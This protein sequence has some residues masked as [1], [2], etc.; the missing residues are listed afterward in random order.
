MKKVIIAI[1]ICIVSLQGVHAVHKS[2]GVAEENFNETYNEVELQNKN[3]TVI[4]HYFEKDKEWAD[5]VLNFTSQAVILMEEITGVPYPPEHQGEYYVEVFG[6]DKEAIGDFGVEIDECGIWIT[7]TI[8]FSEEHN[9]AILAHEISHIWAGYKTTV[10]ERWLAEGFANL[11]AHLV[12]LRMNRTYEA[13]WIKA[14]EFLVYCD[15]KSA[16]D[17]PLD[18]FVYPGDTP[19]NIRFGYAKSM[20]FTYMIHE[21]YGLETIQKT[22]HELWMKSEI[23]DSKEYKEAMEEAVGHNLDDLFSGWVFWGEYKVEFK[24]ADEF[25]KGY[26]NAMSELSS[27]MRFSKENKDSLND[28]CVDHNLEK[29]KL[30]FDAG[31]YNKSVEYSARV[32]NECGKKRIGPSVI[33]VKQAEDESET[34]YE[35]EDETEEHPGDEANTTLLIVGVCFVGIIVL[36]VLA[37]LFLSKDRKHTVIKESDYYSIPEDAVEITTRE[38]VRQLI[39]RDKR[40][41][42][43]SKC[44]SYYSERGWNMYGKCIASG[45]RN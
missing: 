3:V 29:A 18:E 30:E 17:F 19:R 35:S 27:A 20:V 2:C 40:V 13:E 37:I 36:T 14:Q 32:I 5:R 44:G 11:Y 8:G 9:D 45:C 24:E 21:N 31:H 41:V 25:S 1:I 16:L 10:D 26:D 23:P 39:I 43:C 7:P 42:R 22:N 12:L 38:N 34:Y 28:S 6:A 15:G 33:I 4:V